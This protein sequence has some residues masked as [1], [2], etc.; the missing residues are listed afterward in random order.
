MSGFM[1]PLLG[2]VLIGT[3][4]TLLLL[5][6]GRIA[7]IS[8]IVWGALAGAD[9]RSWRWLFSVGLVLGALACHSLT[10]IAV[11]S[12]GA[13]DALLIVVA[14]LLVGFGTKLGSGCTSGHGVCG[15]GRL[16]V[17]SLV[18]TLTFM[19]AGIVTVFVARHLV[20]I[21]G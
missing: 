4:A 17:R 21:G 9:A 3:S 8:G 10:G 11:P 1:V 12:P 13:P 19:F 16:S 5:F 6:N 15:L 20:G 18:A 14:G 2:G 7:G